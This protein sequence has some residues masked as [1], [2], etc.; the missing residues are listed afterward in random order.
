M[1]LKI[2]GLDELQRKLA[3]L[4]RRIENASGPVPFEDLFPPE[5]MRRYT[6][7]KSIEEMLEAS[8]HS[9][10]STEDFEAIPAAEWDAV[11][12]ARTRFATWKEMQQKAG[13]EYIG[14][15]LNM[16]DL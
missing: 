10:D 8:G 12:K 4:Q 3:T 16:D 13:E 5:F 1:D 11:V 7:F 6:D 9:V 15:R 2:T 14:G